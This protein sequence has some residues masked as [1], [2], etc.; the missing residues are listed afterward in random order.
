MESTCALGSTAK[1]SLYSVAHR[2]R[3]LIERPHGP[4]I[5]LVRADPLYRSGW[6]F[7]SPHPTFPTD[8]RS[9]GRGRRTGA[10]VIA[11]DRG[12][13]STCSLNNS[14][15]PRVPTVTPWSSTPTKTTRIARWY[16]R[17]RIQTNC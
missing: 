5:Q 12:R 1:A 16:L 10:N 2:L 3:T 6:R 11:N 13:R 4:V 17:E 7:E 8:C 9:K 14:K 15:K